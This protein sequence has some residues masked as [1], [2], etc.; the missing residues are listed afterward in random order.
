MSEGL[1][2][3]QRGRRETGVETKFGDVKTRVGEVWC[4]RRV[5]L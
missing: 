3:G 2:K 5:L 4:Q 1:R